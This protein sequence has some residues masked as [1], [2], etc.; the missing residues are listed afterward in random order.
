MHKTK[1]MT[2]EQ[3]IVR[4]RIEEDNRRSERRFTA[5]SNV[6]ANVVDHEQGSKN[7]KANKSGSKLG[8][9]G[10][11]S[12]QKFQGKCFNCN[13]VGHKSADCRLP[14]RDKKKEANL[15]DVVTQEV[16]DISLSAVAE[17]KYHT[18]KDMMNAMLLSFGLSQ[19]MW[20]EAIL[21]AN[22]L[23]NKVP[24]KKVNKTPYEL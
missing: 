19:N 12:K 7:R 15:V 20:G 8:Q 4:L 2:I 3:L 10:G 24:R 23:L 11:I 13:K 14:K 22:Y 6:K 5:A 9:K 1:E 18:L 16:S 21:S 17:C